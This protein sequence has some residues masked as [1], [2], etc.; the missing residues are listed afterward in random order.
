MPFF[1]IVIPPGPIDKF[2]PIVIDPTSTLSVSTEMGIDPALKSPVILI[3]AS[4]S[5]CSKNSATGPWDGKLAASLS[6]CSILITR[7]PSFLVTV[8]SP[9]SQV[10]LMCSEPTTGLLF[11]NFTSLLPLLSIM[12]QSTAK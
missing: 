1:E 12:S 10:T 2:P 7:L 8:V 5:L 11:A 4:S 3:I 6:I 9:R